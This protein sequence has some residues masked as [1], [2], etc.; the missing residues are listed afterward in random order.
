MIPAISLFVIVTLSALITRVA[1]IALAHTGLSTES[2]RFQ[3]RSAYTGTGFTT[4]ESEK[5]MFA[6]GVSQAI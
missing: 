1:A 2:A 3:A 4:G 6:R 5:I